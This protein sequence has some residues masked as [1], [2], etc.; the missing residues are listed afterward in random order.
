MDQIAKLCR[1]MSDCQ[2]CGELISD[3]TFATIITK[4]LP[5][6]WDLWVSTF[7]ASQTIADKDQIQSS[8]VISR[9]FEEEQQRRIHKEQQDEVANLAQAHNRGKRTLPKSDSITCNNCKKPGHSA[10]QCYAKGGGS[11]G[12]GP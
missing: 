2:P 7:W 4:S 10:A 12:Q 5:S 9:I 3:W 1:I 11:E 8:N 6:S